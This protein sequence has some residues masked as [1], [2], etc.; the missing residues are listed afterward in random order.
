MSKISVL[1]AGLFL[2]AFNVQLHGQAPTIATPIAWGSFAEFKGTTTVG[3]NSCG[4]VW[5]L[6]GSNQPIDQTFGGAASPG[7]FYGIANNLL[8]ETEYSVRPF[9]RLSNGVFVY[10]NAV[11][12]KT[13]KLPTTELTKNIDGLAEFRG[14]SS[15]ECFRS[16]FVWGLA[17]NPVL[18]GLGNTAKDMNFQGGPFTGFTNDL[19]PEAEYY[20]RSYILTGG[21]GGQPRGTVYG[22]TVKFTTPPRPT[23]DG[24]G[25]N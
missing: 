22:N 12:F 3:T 17:N 20:V 1:I 16:G 14:I 18:P 2:V 11:K 9:V 19:A 15:V 8:P 5:S 10:G 21:L 7:D 6:F 25:R 24:G 23:A 13:P 4:F